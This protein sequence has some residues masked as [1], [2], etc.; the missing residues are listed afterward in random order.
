MNDIGRA[1]DCKGISEDDE[2]LPG[3]GRVGDCGAVRNWIGYRKRLSCKGVRL[4]HPLSRG[5]V[6]VRVPRCRGAGRCKGRPGAEN[7]ILLTVE[8]HRNLAMGKKGDCAGRST[9]EV[10]ISPPGANLVP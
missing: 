1:G 3:K 8:G 9:F 6:P 4:R 10:G 5:C 2:E 7:M